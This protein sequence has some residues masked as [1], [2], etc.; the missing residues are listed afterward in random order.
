MEVQIP[1]KDK[2]KSKV[3]KKRQEGFKELLEL[4]EK[5]ENTDPIFSEH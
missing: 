4:Y 5:S 1:L 3:M 2:L